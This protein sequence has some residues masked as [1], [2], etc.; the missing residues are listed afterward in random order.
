[1]ANNLVTIGEIVTSRDLVLYSLWGLDCDYNSFVPSMSLL[2]RFDKESFEYFFSEL[3]SYVI[4]HALQ[5]NI[6]CFGS[7]TSRN[8][9]YMPYSSNTQ[10]SRSISGWNVSDFL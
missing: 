4:Y 2:M 10:D 3:M 8:G 5:E 7:S 6:T 9:D 1:M